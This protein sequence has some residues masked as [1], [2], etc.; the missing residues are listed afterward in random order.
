MNMVISG[1][2]YQ[3]FDFLEILGNFDAISS[4]CVLTRLYNPNIVSLCP[5]ILRN[6]LI[7]LSNICVIISLETQELRVSQARLH[8]EGDR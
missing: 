8:M 3:F 7:P 4:V 1:F 5:F 6:F 2:G